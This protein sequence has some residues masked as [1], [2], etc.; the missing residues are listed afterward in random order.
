MRT[1]DIHTFYEAK[2]SKSENFL[3]NIT[4]MKAKVTRA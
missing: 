3:S 1:S 2:E 4:K